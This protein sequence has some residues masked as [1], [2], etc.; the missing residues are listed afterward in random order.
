MRSIRNLGARCLQTELM[1]LHGVSLSLPTIHKVLS[2]L[3]A[4]TLDFL[5][6]ITEEM[7]FPI[8][9]IQIDRGR[10]FFAEKVQKK[11]DEAWNQI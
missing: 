4:N 6:C 3:A 1:R 9:R 11:N 7:P 5:N 8:L 2:E 10:K